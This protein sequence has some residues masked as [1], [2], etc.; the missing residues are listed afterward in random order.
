MK[1]SVIP[2]WKVLIILVLSINKIKAME[3]YLRATFYKNQ[4][5]IGWCETK[6]PSISSKIGQ[7][8]PQHI[9]KR[10]WKDG[11][12]ISKTLVSMAILVWADFASSSCFQGKFRILLKLRLSSK[13]PNFCSKHIKW[14]IFH[15]ST[16]FYS[17][18][19]LKMKKWKFWFLLFYC[20]KSR[21]QNGIINSKSHLFGPLL[22]Q[23]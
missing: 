5:D 2:F 3:I 8:D 21:F 22:W 1:G 7:D 13:Q 18:N 19:D 9:T 15:K 14:L 10:F 16:K 4:T 12:T 6:G 23:Q 11:F 17:Q 20:L